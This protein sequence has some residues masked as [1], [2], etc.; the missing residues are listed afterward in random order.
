MG[1]RPALVINTK[2]YHVKNLTNSLIDIPLGCEATWALLTPKNVTNASKVQ[3]ISVCSIYCKPDSRTKTRLSDHISQAYSIISSK[4][5]TG[6]HFIIAG[7]TNDL[8][9]DAILQLD[10]RMKQMVVGM[11]RMNPPRMLDPNYDYSWMFL[12]SPRDSSSSGRGSWNQWQGL[13]SYDPGN[14][15]SQWD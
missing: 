6:L 11:T 3:K 15:T 12:P 4:F 2:Q 13:G 7:D 1:G 9:L 10:P 5:P 8:K 14:E